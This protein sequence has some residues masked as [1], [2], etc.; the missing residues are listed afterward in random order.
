M[1]G[2]ELLQGQLLKLNSKT[3]PFWRSQAPI[4]LDSAMVVGLGA[5][6]T[7]HWGRKFQRL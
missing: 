2:A 6:Y 5:Y 1:I 3:K 7:W 4:L